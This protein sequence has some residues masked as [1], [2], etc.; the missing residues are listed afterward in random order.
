VAAW[1]VNRPEFIGIWLALKVAGGWEAWA[2]GRRIIWSTNN[3]RH[4]ALVTGR[5]LFNSTVIGSGLSLLGAVASALFIQYGIGGQP[6]R[7]VA[8]VLAASVPM[9]LTCW[10]FN[11][12]ADR[13]AGAAVK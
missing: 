3:V 13:L 6:I 8:L 5:H 9:Y 4:E 1:L 7:A 11:R 2:K 12:E 10:W